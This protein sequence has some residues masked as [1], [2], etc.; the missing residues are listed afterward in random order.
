MTD[1]EQ[2]ALDRIEAKIED[3]DKKLDKVRAEDIPA[4]RVDVAGLKVKAGAWGMMG[5]ALV[6]LGTLV[7][8][9]LKR[10]GS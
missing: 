3:L 7:V 6:G 1:A 5:G 10:G 9:L 8:G 4:L 2:S